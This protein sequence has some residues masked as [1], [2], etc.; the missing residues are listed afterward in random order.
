MYTILSKIYYHMLYKD[1]TF[2][3]NNIAPTSQARNPF[4]TEVSRKM[5][6]KYKHEVWVSSKPFFS[7]EK[8][9]FR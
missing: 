3:G 5:V 6:H 4:K 1:P 2:V 7:F 9:N 8:G